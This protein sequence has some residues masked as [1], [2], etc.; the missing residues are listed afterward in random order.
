[1]LR[2]SGHGETRRWRRWLEEH[3]REPEREGRRCCAGR[4]RGKK[5]HRGGRK[6]RGTER[7]P[8]GDVIAAAPS[9]AR[10]LPEGEVALFPLAQ[11][12]AAVAGGHPALANV[13]LRAAE[14]AREDGERARERQGQYEGEHEEVRPPPARRGHG[15]WCTR[16]RGPRQRSPDDPG[17]H[18]SDSAAVQAEASAWPWSH[19][20]MQTSR[21]SPWATTAPPLWLSS[22]RALR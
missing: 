14:G 5:S 6:K 13:V 1:M 2:L 22:P 16:N 3:E 20:V 18:G 12:A 11:G 15:T 4:A 7:P 8:E 10:H 19:V 9:T 21:G 17:P